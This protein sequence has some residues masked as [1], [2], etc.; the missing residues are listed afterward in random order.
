MARCNS[1]QDSGL[2]FLYLKKVV[3]LANLA[4]HLHCSPR[5]VQRRL[6]KWQAIS[7]YNRNGSCYTLPETA[8]FDSNGLWRCQG[9]FFSKFG[10]LSETFVRL[11]ANSQAGLTAAEAD[12]LLG[13]KSGS[14][15][16]PLRNH[17][18]LVREK[19]HGV[20]VYFNS[21]PERCDSQRQARL[22]LCELARLP[23]DF[24]AVAILVAKIKDPTLNNKSLS[25]QLKGQGISI[26]SES[27]E[28]LFA[29][30]GL[31]LKKTPRSA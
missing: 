7:S 17:P 16:W 23:T 20:Y 31:T 14:F 6:A 18:E 3:T 11:V 24:E 27:I 21:A 8:K 15:L 5:T 26:A 19:H 1:T 22:S 30:H 13:V 29:K 4:L 9:A 25:R 12:K 2:K 10:T 28:M